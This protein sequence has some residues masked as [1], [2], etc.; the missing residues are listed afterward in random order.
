MY[1]DV[2]LCIRKW[3]PMIM[4]SLACDVMYDDVT[5][6]MMMWHYVWW[7]DTMY[8]EMNPYDHAISRMWRYVWWCDTMYDDV[9]LCMMM[10][11]YV[12]GNEPLWSRSLDSPFDQLGSVFAL[13]NQ[14]SA[15]RQYPVKILPFIFSFLTRKRIERLILIFQ[16]FWQY[17]VETP[18]VCVCV[19]V[20]VC[21]T[22]S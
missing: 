14:Q 19:C 17:P 6:C 7:C 1:D 10:W 3:T 9:T 11:H 13:Q 18:R 21:H 15:H 5:L 16:L 22:E 20:C 2:T 12:S 4:R 8:Q